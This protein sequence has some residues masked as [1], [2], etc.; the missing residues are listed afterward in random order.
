M[1]I[2]LD[3]QISPFIAPW[4]S[5]TFDIEAVALKNIGLRDATDRAIF[6]AARRAEAVVLTKDRDLAYLVTQLGPPPQ[7]VWVT[8]G[9]TSNAKLKAILTQAWP[10]ARTLIERGEAIIEIS[11][12]TI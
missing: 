12:M 9:N 6:L 10:S 3:A 5:S 1:K 2:W 4:L 11:D 8:C 7:I